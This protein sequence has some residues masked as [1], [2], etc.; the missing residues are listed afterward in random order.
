LGAGFGTGTTCE[1]AAVP[2]LAPDAA[3]SSA[4]P[5]RSP[6]CM[7]RCAINIPDLYST[8][9]RGHF[10]ALSIKVDIVFT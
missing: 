7:Y 1:K 8:R 4:S 5:Q 3:I 10:I 2:K 6:R 9:R